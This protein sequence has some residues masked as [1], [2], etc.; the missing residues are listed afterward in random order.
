MK[1]KKDKEVGFVV[2]WGL[3]NV[4]VYADSLLAIQRR[5]RMVKHD[6]KGMNMV[7]AMQ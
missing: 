7:T 5:I 3:S 4:F 6:Q 1:E 2:Y